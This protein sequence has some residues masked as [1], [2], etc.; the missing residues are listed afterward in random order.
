MVQAGLGQGFDHDGALG[1]KDFHGVMFDPARLR[2]VLLEFTLGGAD[3]V[4]IAVEN[5]GPG[6]G[7]ALVQGNDVV[8]V[9]CFG[10][11]DC[12]EIE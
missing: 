12:L 3:H 10:H 9:L 2:V 7:R 11:V 6:T 8:L 4:G 1:G 5:N